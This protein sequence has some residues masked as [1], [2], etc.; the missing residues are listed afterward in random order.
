MLPILELVISC[1][2]LTGRLAIRGEKRQR[3]LAGKTARGCYFIRINFPFPVIQ[4]RYSSPQ[5]L[6]MT[7]FAAPKISSLDIWRGFA[8]LLHTGVAVTCSE[9]FWEGMDSLFLMG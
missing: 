3:L 6:M 9:L 4:R 2:V 7:I 8:D 1:L 5:W